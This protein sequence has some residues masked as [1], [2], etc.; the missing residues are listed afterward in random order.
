M[1]KL[2]STIV[3]PASLHKLAGQTIIIIRKQVIPVG[4]DWG[5]PPDVSS[6]DPDPWSHLQSDLFKDKSR[7]ELWDREVPGGA[8]TDPDPCR[9][10]LEESSNDFHR[11]LTC[12]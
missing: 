6:P 1:N 11:G 3:D 5:T 7:E 10:C 12:F 9:K 4:T 2:G 8:T